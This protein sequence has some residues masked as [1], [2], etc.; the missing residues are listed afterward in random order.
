MIRGKT[1]K[2]QQLELKKISVFK[3][4][5]LE[6]SDGINVF[7]GEN[8]T[9]KSH[10]LKLLY[11]ILKANEKSENGGHKITSLETL[12]PLKLVRTFLPDNDAIGRLVNRRVGRGSGT[13]RLK[14]DFGE[15]AFKLTTLGKFTLEQNSLKR[16]E[17]SLFIPSREA[18]ALFEGFLAAVEERELSFDDTYRD[19]CLALS[20]SL[21]KGPRLDEAN[22]LA[23][24]LENVLGGKVRLKAGKFFVYEK[25]GFI[26]APLLA[27][28]MRKIASL[29]HLIL[30]GSLIRNGFL[31]WDEPEANLN[32]KLVTMIVKVLRDLAHSGIQVFIAT[33]DYLLSRELS[34]ASE[35]KT[36]PRVDIKFFACTH[37]KE[38]D[39]VE[40][41]EGSSFSEVESNPI[42]Q[43]WVAHYDREL[44]LFSAVDKKS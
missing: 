43:E 17:R 31:F 38:K 3:S 35:Y 27:E 39:T 30:N 7:I 9:G 2:I 29:I 15:I 13:V 4:T 19:L 1:M 34:L 28:G 41:E 5:T 10:L 23:K 8:A 14:T 36:K 37:A 16:S 24:P 12:L 42:L 44:D 22:A 26:E 25:N 40:V 20:S 6:F 11:C 21:T 18:F 32:P 33:H